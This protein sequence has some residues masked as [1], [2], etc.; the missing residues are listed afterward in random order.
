MM[1]PRIPSGVGPPPSGR[2][3][4]V[5]VVIEPLEITLLDISN[6]LHHF[7]GVDR[8]PRNGERVGCF[9]WKLASMKSASP[10]DA[11]ALEVRFLRHAG[12]R[13]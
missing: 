2:P 13:R 10:V 7:G 4:G 8:S 1:L 5:N 3:S 6:A 12:R 9:R 11:E